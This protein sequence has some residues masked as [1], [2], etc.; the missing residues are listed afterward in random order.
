MTQRREMAQRR[1][2]TQRRAMTQKE[3]KGC[4]VV[5]LSTKRGTRRRNQKGGM[6]DT[7]V[8]ASCG[9]CVVCVCGVCV[10]VCLYVSMRVCMCFYV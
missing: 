5:M 10:C 9:V 8:W 7:C 3:E 4:L 1:E 6:K 2:M